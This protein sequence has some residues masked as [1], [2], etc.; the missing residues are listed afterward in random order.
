MNCTVCGFVDECSNLIHR[1]TFG[2]CIYKEVSKESSIFFVCHD[3]LRLF[4]KELNMQL[5]RVMQ[6]TSAHK[7]NSAK[8]TVSFAAYITLSH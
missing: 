5:Y 8:M 1:N 4:K 7:S 3:Y 2:K 6:H